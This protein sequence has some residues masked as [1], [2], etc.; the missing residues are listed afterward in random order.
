VTFNLFVEARGLYRVEVLEEGRSW[1]TS[2][3]SC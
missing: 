2:S 3:A 1:T